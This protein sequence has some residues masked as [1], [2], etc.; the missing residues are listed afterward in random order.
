MRELTTS[1]LYTGSGRLLFNRVVPSEKKTEYMAIYYASAGLVGGIG[2]IVAG[3]ALDYFKGIGLQG[4]ILI[5]PVDPFT[6]LFAGALLLLRNLKEQGARMEPALALARMMGEE[7]YFIRLWRHTRA[8]FGTP[9]S[10][11]MLSHLEK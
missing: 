8:E 1:G 6:P 3:R 4:H 7:H 9:A 11:A 5:L 2:P 10:S